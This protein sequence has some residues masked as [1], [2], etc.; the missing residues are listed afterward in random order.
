MAVKRRVGRAT[1]KPKNMTLIRCTIRLF[2][3]SLYSIKA[4]TMN[5]INNIY[6][7]TVAAILGL[8]LTTLSELRHRLHL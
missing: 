2:L 3:N 4:T 6:T 7:K 5:P 8:M 1:A